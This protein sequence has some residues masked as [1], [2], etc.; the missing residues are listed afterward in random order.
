MTDEAP[1]TALSPDDCAMRLRSQQLGR[2]IT[3]VGDVVD[4]FPV[5]YVVD[6]DDSLLFRTA[7]GTKLVELTV[8][9]E[10]LFEVDDHTDDEAWSV[11][12]RGSASHAD[13]TA[14]IEHADALG[15][16]PWI[17]TV[18]YNLVRITPRTL[19]GRWFRR[20]PEPERYGVIDG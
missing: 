5:N 10:V 20:G 17:P 16:A 11:V 6:D 7:E 3:R 8:N 4:V 2:I 14:E 18:K 9:T 19:T 1:V 13:T 15:L 12:V